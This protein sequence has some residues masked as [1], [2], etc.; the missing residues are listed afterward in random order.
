MICRVVKMWAMVRG[1]DCIVPVTHLNLTLLVCQFFLTDAQLYHGQVCRY[2]YD[3]VH[4]EYHAEWT[5]GVRMESSMAGAYVLLC[6]RFDRI[7]PCISELRMLI[8][9]ICVRI[10]SS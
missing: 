3:V 2:M 6:M 4:C 7:P 5:L 1:S 8:S 9:A 10:P